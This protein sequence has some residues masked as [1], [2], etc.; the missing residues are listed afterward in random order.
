LND[1]LESASLEI[2]ANPSLIGTEQWQY[3]LQ[4]FRTK[5]L[6]SLIR[7]FASYLPEDHKWRGSQDSISTPPESCSASS[8]SSSRS[9]SDE[10]IAHS[11]QPSLFDDDAIVTHEPFPIQSH[12]PLSPRSMTM[13]S[14]ESADVVHHAYL[15]NTLTP[16]RTMSFSESESERFAAL[17]DSRSTDLHDDDD[18][19]SQSCD[20]ESPSTSVSDLSDAPSYAMLDKDESQTPESDQTPT[21]KP[22]PTTTESFFETKP[23]PIHRRHRSVS[24]ATMRSRHPLSQ[25]HTPHHHSHHHH[26]HDTPAS[27][28]AIRSRRMACSPVQVNGGRRR[29]SPG[30]PAARI[31]KPITDPIRSRP[32]GRRRMEG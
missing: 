6:D 19:T 3:A 13:C 20:A 26:H 32:R 12:L 16:A 23:S 21:P 8:R 2:I 10:S 11:D 24:P 18:D 30:E 29:R 25:V 1:S 22:E 7:Y 27:L 4:L 17:Q 5:S 14:D 28:P 31:Q 15:L 9:A